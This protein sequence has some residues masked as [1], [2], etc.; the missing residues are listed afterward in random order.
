MQRCSLNRRNSESVDSRAVRRAAVT[1]DSYGTNSSSSP[2]ILPA[3]TDDDA[4]GGGVGARERVSTVRAPSGEDPLREQARRLAGYIGEAN[5]MQAE[6]MLGGQAAGVYLWRVS[7]NRPGAVLSM[8]SSKR[9]VHHAFSLDRQNSTVLM[10][11]KPLSEP[12][13]SLEAVVSLLKRKLEQTSCKLTAPLS[14]R[15]GPRIAIADTSKW[16]LLFVL[17]TKGYRFISASR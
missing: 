15:T 3:G 14:V 10:N 13:E 4:V 6:G 5:R 17:F 9:M 8:V 12:C 2:G 7:G 11:G 16:F 1:Y